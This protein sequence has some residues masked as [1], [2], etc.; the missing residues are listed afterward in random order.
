MAEAGGDRCGGDTVLAC[1]CLGDDPF[2][3][4]PLCQKNLAEAVV[5]LVAAGVV[6]VLA[7]EVDL[8]TAAQTLRGRNVP[9][10]VRQALGEIEFGGSAGIKRRKTLQFLFECWIVPGL[11]PMSL[12]FKDQRHQR[13]GDETPA[14]NAEHALFVRASAEGIWLGRLV[15]R[16]YPSF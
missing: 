7:L 5:D 4:H 13:F 14:K 3:A 12:E 1:A 10:V 9:Q 8:R 6:Q 15:H 2:L 16:R 11:V